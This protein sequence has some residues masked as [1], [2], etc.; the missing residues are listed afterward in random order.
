MTACHKGRIV[1]QLEFPV[2]LPLLK[3]QGRVMHSGREACL[4]LFARTDRARKIASALGIWSGLS[5]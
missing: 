2:G 1:L 3:V 5:S 4:I